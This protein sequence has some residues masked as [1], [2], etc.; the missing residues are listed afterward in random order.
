MKDYNQEYFFIRRKG[1]NYP[2]IEYVNWPDSAPLPDKPEMGDFHSC[3]YKAIVS[4][5]IK[6]IINLINLK[7]VQFIPA[8]ICNQAG[9]IVEGYYIIHIYHF[10][11]AM[12]KEKSDWEED[13]DNP[14]R[15]FSIDELVL[16]NE[17][18]DKIPL[19]DRLVFA[20]KE[21]PLTTV[22]HR[23]VIDK[24]LALQPTGLGVYCLAEWNGSNPFEDEFWE[25]VMS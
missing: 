15:A 1:I 19:E 5:T 9:E 4:E 22:Y 20:L 13:D 12:D 7:E 17:K 25:Y 16:D 3:A 24:I 8:T 10:I 23:S 21:H 11:Q 2:L 6:N 14:E 18:L